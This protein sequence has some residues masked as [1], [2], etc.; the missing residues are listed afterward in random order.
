[1]LDGFLLGVLC[2]LTALLIASMLLF[3][4]RILEAIDGE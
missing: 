2:T 4:Q 1:M 3:G